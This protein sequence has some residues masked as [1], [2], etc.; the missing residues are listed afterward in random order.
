MPASLPAVSMVTAVFQAAVAGLVISIE[1]V[2][3]GAPSTTHESTYS[4][5]LRFADAVPALMTSGESSM[6]IRISALPPTATSKLLGMGPPVG[7]A[8][9]VQSN[10]RAGP[11]TGRLEVFP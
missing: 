11:S 10:R 7:E 1:Y 2:S 9:E 3:P 8:A 5:G 6:N 4:P